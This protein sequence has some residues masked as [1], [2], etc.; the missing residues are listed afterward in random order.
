MVAEPTPAERTERTERTL[1][2]AERTPERAE[3][4]PERTEPAE[5]NGMT[6]RGS[7][8]LRGMDDFDS[9]LGGP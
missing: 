9:E 6:G 4:T 3:R 7:D 8:G 2:R 1:E 5:G